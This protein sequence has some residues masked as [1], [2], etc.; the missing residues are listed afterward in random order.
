MTPTEYAQIALS[1]T[2][3]LSLVYAAFNV[4]WSKRR[5]IK[6][7][8]QHKALLIFSLRNAHNYYVEHEE[9]ELARECLDSIKELEKM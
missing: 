9:Y 7:L 5:V 3:T 6:M 4:F 8:D 1:I 2:S